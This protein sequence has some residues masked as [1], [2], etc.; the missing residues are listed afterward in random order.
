MTLTEQ[1][2]QQLQK[3]FDKVADPET[4]VQIF[5]CLTPVVERLIDARQPLAAS[6]PQKDLEIALLT[7]QVEKLREV[8]QAVSEA[9][10]EDLRID[11]KDIT[12]AILRCRIALRAALDTNAPEP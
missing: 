5:N 4:R 1:E 8:C 3:C 10:D 9:A 6:A 12:I 7:A 2:N 11:L